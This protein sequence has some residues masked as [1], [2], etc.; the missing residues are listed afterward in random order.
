VQLDLY[1]ARPD[2]ERQVDIAELQLMLALQHQG[3]LHRHKVTSI[4]FGGDDNPS[5]L[6]ARSG[7][8][9]RPMM[10]AAPIPVTSPQC[11]GS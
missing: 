1:H 5:L 9:R 2:C 7:D 6:P 4:G 8:F 3:G 10:K 11:Y